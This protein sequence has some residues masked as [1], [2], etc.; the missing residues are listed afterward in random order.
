MEFL[1]R[2][3]FNL[4]DA[5]YF[6]AM[7]VNHILFDLNQTMPF[8]VDPL[9]VR[10]FREWLE[11]PTISGSFLGNEPEEYITRM[12]VD[13]ALDGVCFR[14]LPDQDQWQDF[15]SML[16][17]TDFDPGISPEV[18]N[19]ETLKLIIPFPLLMSGL[20]QDQLARIVEKAN[21]G[22]L[23]IAGPFEDSFFSSEWFRPDMGIVLDGG[24]EEKTGIKSFEEL[25]RIFERFQAL[26]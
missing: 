22:N 10:R 6:S 23:Y 8:F 5:R 1:A 11:G 14:Q 13:C 3:V 4:T 2:S 16:F 19:H 12:I 9:Q 17:W 20:K 25:D 7:G 21:Q 26:L 18:Y 24:E 15:A